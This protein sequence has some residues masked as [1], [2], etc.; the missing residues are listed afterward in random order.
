ML[1]WIQD[2]QDHYQRQVDALAI[3]RQSVAEGA[4]HR[5]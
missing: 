1:Q 5:E 2:Q 4:S 3:V